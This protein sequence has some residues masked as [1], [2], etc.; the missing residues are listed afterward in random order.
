MYSIFDWKEFELS[1]LWTLFR[2]SRNKCTSEETQGL[3]NSIWCPQRHHSSLKCV[4]KLSGKFH[5]LVW[6]YTLFWDCTYI[7]FSSWTLCSGQIAGRK[8]LKIKKRGHIVEHRNFYSFIQ[9]WTIEWI[10]W[11]CS[12]RRPRWSSLWSRQS[13]SKR[14]GRSQHHMV[15]Q[16]TR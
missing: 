11:R 8:C 5:F 4:L 14:M 1:Y 3:E 7:C 15:Q 2:W 9:M 16:T 10:N 12:L 13:W 6:F